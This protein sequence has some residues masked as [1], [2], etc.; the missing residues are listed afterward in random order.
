MARKDGEFLHGAFGKH[1][2]KVINGKQ[3]VYPKPVPGTMKQTNNTKKAANIFAMAAMIARYFRKSLFNMINRFGDNGM[4]NRLTALFNQSLR[5]SRDPDS[6][7]YRFEADSFIGLEGF[8]FNT[9]SKLSQLMLNRP[10][11]TVNEG[12]LTVTVPANRI[13]SELKFPE[14]SFECEVWISVS[15]IRLEEVLKSTDVES[16]LITVTRDKQSLE[17]QEL[18]FMVPD[19]CL[20]IVSTFLQYANY[21]KNKPLII[22]NKKL[23][24]GQIN[25]ALITPGIYQQ[26][27]QLVWEKMIINPVKKKRRN[28]G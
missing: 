16:Q 21:S 3:F 23:N 13:D 9:D 10:S 22:N 4:I 8:E 12:I 6:G 14:S 19:G 20:C 11:I 25:K 28:K 18:N 27:D 24:P 1:I 26:N 7:V 5:D 2:Y 17:Q 15:L